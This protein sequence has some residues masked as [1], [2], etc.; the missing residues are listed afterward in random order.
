MNC[1]RC[2]FEIEELET[3]ARLSDEA[4]AH[5]SACSVCRAFH[6]ERQS[7]KKLIGSL[8]QVSAPPDFDFQL[9]ARINAAKSAGNHRPAWRSF[10][11]SAPAIGLAA[12]FALL[13]AGVLI[14]KQTKTAP[15]ATTNQ[16][17][18]IAGKS[19][20][21]KIEGTGMNSVKTPEAAENKGQKVDGNKEGAEQVVADAGMTKPSRVHPVVDGKHNVRRE[22]LRPDTAGAQS[23]PSNDLAVSPAPQVV[24]KGAVPFNAGMNQVVELPVRSASQPMRVFV[25]DRDGAKRRVTLAPVTFGSQDFA[26]LNPQMPSPQGIW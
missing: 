9:R 8:E 12:T 19:V 22:R 11:A 1:Q 24:P 7:L 5:L 3:G 2:R 6:D 15:Y 16:T 20:E 18:A 13:V 10:I 21:T 4:R 14:Y 23:L 26:G 17:E 25:N